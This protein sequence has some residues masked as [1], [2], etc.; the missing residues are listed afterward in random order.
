[1][2][3]CSKKSTKQIVL[4]ALCVSACTQQGSLDKNRQETGLQADMAS[5]NPHV[6]RFHKICLAENA[7]QAK[8]YDLASVQGFSDASDASLKAAGLLQLKKTVLEI[9][10]GGAPVSETQKLMAR[11][12]DTGSVLALEQR[13]EKSRPVSTY[14]KLYAASENYLEMCEALGKVIG[15]APDANKKYKTGNAHFINWHV[16]LHGKNT[17]ISCEAPGSTALPDFKGGVLSAIYAG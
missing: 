8:R 16:S 10:G 15:R 11:S 3:L 6:E 14:C 17:R 12:G 4:L 1:M 9:P 13:L 7:S 2:I 5:A